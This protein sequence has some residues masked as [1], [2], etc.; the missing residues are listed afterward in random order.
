M[1]SLILVAVCSFLFWSPAAA[2]EIADVEVAEEVVQSDGTVLSLN[3]AGIRSKFFFK[4]YIASLYLETLGTDSAAVIG[5]DGGK[6]LVMHFLYDEVGKDDLVEAWNEGFEGNGT[7]DQL[8]A[9]A[10]KI[11]TFN[12]LFD[13][14]KAGD[15]ILLDYIPG[16]GT[17][18][19]IRGEEKGRIDGKEFNDLLLSIWLGKEPV[20]EDLRDELLGR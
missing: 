12:A 11:A 7:P 3:G 17:T 16:G 20:G 5:G 4:I 10:D 9:L 6:R 14:V 8:T 2:R 13:N 1:K 15:R 18:V 19:T